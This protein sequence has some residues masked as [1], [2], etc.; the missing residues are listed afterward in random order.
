M[1]RKERRKAEAAEL[2]RDIGSL[3][4]EVRPANLIDLPRSEWKFR[5]CGADHVAVAMHTNAGYLHWTKFAL[6]DL[7]NDLVSGDDLERVLP[8]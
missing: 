6:V 3:G 5:R 4:L 8:A 7:P 2:G 1:N